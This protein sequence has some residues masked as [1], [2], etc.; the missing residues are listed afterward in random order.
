M[1]LLSE[2]KFGVIAYD[3]LIPCA[4]KDYAKLPYCIKSLENLIP[5]PQNIFV[6]SKDQVRIK[7]NICFVEWIDEYEALPILI[8]DIN[9][10]RPNWI[11]QQILKMTQEWTVNDFY[12]CV[13][14]D[15]I[16][17]R[18]LELFEP[19]DQFGVNIPRF[20]ISSQKQNHR[21]Y[22]DFME[23]VFN[24]TKQV[25]HSFI[26]DITMFHKEILKRIIPEGLTSRSEWLLAACNEYLSDDCLIGEPEIYGN[27]IYKNFR[28]AYTTYPI[29]VAMYGKY[30]R[31]RYISGPDLYTN[32][33]IEAIIE[34]E[35]NSS[36]DIV[37]VHSWT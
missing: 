9:Y 19:P 7:S 33:E 28:E 2:E 14:S 27:W 4:P 12:L 11:Y 5:A 8:S 25:D 32:K 6:I 20:L 29:Q 3:V 36:N 24:L 13:D 1:T 30:L 18:P 35:K 37:A 31:N 17:N 21:P 26:S 23:K 10:R 34:K 16:I 22:F 15:L